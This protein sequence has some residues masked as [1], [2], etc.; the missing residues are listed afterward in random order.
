MDHASYCVHL[1]SSP[2]FDIV[3]VGVTTRQSRRAS[4]DGENLLPNAAE[5]MEEMAGEAK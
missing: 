2:P 4:M 5:V 1:T 3:V